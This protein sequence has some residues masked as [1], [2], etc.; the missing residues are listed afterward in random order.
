MVWLP[1]ICFGCVDD[2]YTTMNIIRKKKQFFLQL[3]Y[4]QGMRASWWFYLLYFAR[5][6]G[7]LTGFLC[8]RW[9]WLWT[10]TIVYPVS[11]CRSLCVILC[12]V[13]MLCLAFGRFRNKLL[14]VHIHPYAVL[15]IQSYHPSCFVVPCF[16][17]LF[18]NVVGSTTPSVWTWD[19]WILWTL[20]C[21]HRLSSVHWV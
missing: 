8:I 18:T 4:L 1:I 7:L 5:I 14:C 15:H 2:C 20:V 11:V 12:F 3:L 10:R 6:P 19:G 13:R 21:S 16:M 17:S 9:L